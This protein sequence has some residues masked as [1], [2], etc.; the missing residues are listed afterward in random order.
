MSYWLDDIYHKHKYYDPY[1]N[2][3]D[4]YYNS[5]Y[6]NYKNYDRLYEKYIGPGYGKS[7]LYT[8][9]LDEVLKQRTEKLKEQKQTDKPVEQKQTDKPVEQKQANDKPVEQKANE[10]ETKKDSDDWFKPITDVLK[11][12]NNIVEKALNGEKNQNVYTFSKLYTMENGKL[13]EK[14]SSEMKEMGLDVNTNFG[15]FIETFLEAFT[16]C[17]EEKKEETKEEKKEETKEE[18]QLSESDGEEHNECVCDMYGNWVPIQLQKVFKYCVD[19]KYPDVEEYSYTNIDVVKTLLT[20]SINTND[21]EAF[22][23]LL[24]HFEIDLDF[25]DYLVKRC[26]NRNHSRFTTCIQKYSQVKIL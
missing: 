4:N 11:S 25:Y 21:I 7:K 23:F 20:T 3:Y 26:E 8:S 6:N 17:D 14:S 18:K 15:K 13:V 19:N 9:L 12:V 16:E 2:S 1:Y 5:Y 24:K 10:Q 22:E